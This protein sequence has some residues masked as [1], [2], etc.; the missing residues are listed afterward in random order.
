MSFFDLSN[1]E[2]FSHP[3]EQE[4]SATY[5]LLL[6]TNRNRFE[7]LATYLLWYSKGECSFR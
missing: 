7:V 2:Y 3:N 6:Q 1:Y 4:M 5:D